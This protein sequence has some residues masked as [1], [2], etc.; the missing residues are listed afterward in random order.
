MRRGGWN[1]V[2]MMGKSSPGLG[3][4]LWW[5]CIPN[6]N[7]TSWAWSTFPGQLKLEPAIELTTD[8]AH[9][10]A[11]GYCPYPM[12]T[13]SGQKS[14]VGYSGRFVNTAALPRFSCQSFNPAGIKLQPHSVPAKHLSGTYHCIFPSHL[15]EKL[16]QLFS[17]PICSAY[18]MPEFLGG[19]RWP[20]QIYN[21]MEWK[22][23]MV[24]C[25]MVNLLTPRKAFP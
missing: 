19:S 21:K 25:G 2:G 10:G 9:S 13:T 4:D 23:K 8:R 6:S 16:S 24:P 18:S 12:E 20:E 7:P 11:R 17:L 22:N 3:Q 15:L 14:P 5:W 1:G